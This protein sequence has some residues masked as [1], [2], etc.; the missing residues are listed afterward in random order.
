LEIAGIAA[1]I[2]DQIWRGVE[3]SAFEG[4]GE[5]MEPVL[6]CAGWGGVPGLEKFPISKG[7]GI[8]DH[9]AEANA[10]AGEAGFEI[11]ESP[12]VVGEEAKVGLDVGEGEFARGAVGFSEGPDQAAAAQSQGIDLELEPREGLV[13]E[14]DLGFGQGE[15][16]TERLIGASELDIF[17]D[18]AAVPAEPEARELEVEAA[19]AEFF[20]ERSFDEGGQADLVE[21]KQGGQGDQQQQPNEDSEAA[22]TDA[23]NPPKTSLLAG[24]H[25]RGCQGGW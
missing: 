8:G 11:I 24:G 19:G 17:G 20:E 2:Q 25:I 10:S 7:G 18:E 23:A 14:H 6:Q 5:A 13:V 15:P 22:K 3:V 4:I 21:V 9:G 16:G 1:Q 12:L